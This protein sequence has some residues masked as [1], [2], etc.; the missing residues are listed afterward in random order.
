MSYTNNLMSHFFHYHKYMSNLH[1]PYYY[2]RMCNLLNFQNRF[3]IISNNFN[4]KQWCYRHII[5]LDNYICLDLIYF[6]CKLNTMNYNLH[7]LHIKKSKLL[8]L[9]NKITLTINRNEI[10]IFSRLTRTNWNRNSSCSS[11]SIS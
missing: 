9:K 10:I 6:P 5:L 4:I 2:S 7:M 3:N 8:L 1:Y 11:S